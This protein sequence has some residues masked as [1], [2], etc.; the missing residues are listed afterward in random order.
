MSHHN[1]DD[2]AQQLPTKGRYA[3]RAAEVIKILDK[4]V[5]D[6]FH[7]VREQPIWRTLTDPAT[8][9]ETCLAIF[10][11]IFLSIY[12]YQRHTTEAGFHMLGRLPKTE[13]TMLKLAVLHKAEEAG[14]AEW[15]LRD[16]LT[17]GGEKKIA[18][19]AP[20]SPATFAVASVWW[21]MAIT[22]DPM[23]YF[24]AEYLFEYLTYTVTQALLP[25]FKQRKLG[26]NGLGFIIDHA[27]EDEKHTKLVRHLICDCVTRYPE[28]E[29][30][31]MRCYEYFHHVYPILVWNEAYERAVK[32]CSNKS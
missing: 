8:P 29:L 25:H 26:A 1:H 14:H 7:L 11:E 28:S 12:S 23:G 10:R 20:P 21:R 15:A 2:E 17:L 22:E 31:M 19:T 13:T 27:T 32:Y 9:N 18:L 4:R 6:V 24:G 3:P 16:Y 30:V 5:E